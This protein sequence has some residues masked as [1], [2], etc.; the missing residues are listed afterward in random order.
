MK[1]WWLVQEMSPLTLG[2]A[3]LTEIE[4]WSAEYDPIS[5]QIRQPPVLPSPVQSP[6]RSSVYKPV[7]GRS[8]LDDHYLLHREKGSKKCIYCKR[9]E[10]DPKHLRN[11]KRNICS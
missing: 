2:F 10:F 4:E 11:L 9:S 1:A 3:K 5:T 6:P 7:L 8:K